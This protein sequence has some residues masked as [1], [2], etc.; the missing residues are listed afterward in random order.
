[1]QTILALWRCG[2]V[3]VCTPPHRVMPTSAQLTQVQHCALDT[4]AG[5]SSRWAPEQGCACTAQQQ[6]QGLNVPRPTLGS[7][8]KLCPERVFGGSSPVQA[9]LRHSM[10][11]C[12]R[13]QQQSGQFKG[14]GGTMVKAITPRYTTIL[15]QLLRT[16]SLLGLQTSP[17]RQVHGQWKCPKR[18]WMNP[19]SCQLHSAPQSASGACRR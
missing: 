17:H 1:M 13:T 9:C 10:M 16:D 18:C 11:V 6:G 8:T 3:C 12:S 15:V 4:A 2:A 19:L 7:C 5:T 14:V